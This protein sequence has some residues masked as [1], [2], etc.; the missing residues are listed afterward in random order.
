MEFNK[1]KNNKRQPMEFRIKK[2]LKLVKINK[3]NKIKNNKIIM[4]SQL[5]QLNLLF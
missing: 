4:E 3:N 5:N 1:M 2:I